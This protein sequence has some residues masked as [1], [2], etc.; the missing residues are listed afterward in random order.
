MK[1]WIR[2][3][4]I[5]LLKKYPQ[6]YDIIITSKMNSFMLHLYL[7]L[8]EAEDTNIKEER[9]KIINIIMTIL[10]DEGID[11]IYKQITDIKYQKLISVILSRIKV[12]KKELIDEKKVDIEL[13]NNLDNLY[14]LIKEK[15]IIFNI[16]DELKDLILEY[17]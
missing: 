15:I 3:D 12:L 13:Y 6:Y 4:C 11:I 2:K 8:R 1:L 17:Y 9:L 16:M 14:N 5:N 7:L 10:Y